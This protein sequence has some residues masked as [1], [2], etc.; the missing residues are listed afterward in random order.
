[1]ALYPVIESHYRTILKILLACIIAFR[2]THVQSCTVQIPAIPDQT[3]IID[4]QDNLYNV[5]F[6]FSPDCQGKYKLP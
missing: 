6:S 4:G 5:S 2:W 1:M 3:Y